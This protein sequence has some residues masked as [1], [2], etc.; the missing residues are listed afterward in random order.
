MFTLEKSI[1][2][3]G[4]TILNGIFACGYNASKYYKDT[5]YY[6]KILLLVE[7]NNL[8]ENLKKC[9]LYCC[10]YEKEIL[11]VEYENI[12]NL[13]WVDHYVNRDM[14]TRARDVEKIEITTEDKKIYS[15][16]LLII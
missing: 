16:L 11:F 6:N 10:H 2:D 13:N 7:K 4:I 8:T 14:Y 5:I 12:K 15:K 3:I 9:S 1:N